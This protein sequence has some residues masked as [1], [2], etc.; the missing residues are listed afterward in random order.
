FPNPC[1]DIAFGFSA[2]VFLGFSL[3]D[4][5]PKIPFQSHDRLELT[6][7]LLSGVGRA[8]GIGQLESDTAYSVH[9]L[10]SE[11]EVEHPHSHSHSPSHETSD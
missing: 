3:Y 6:A 8:W 1:D 9:P 7:T 2:G 11:T 4:I 5:L 10:G